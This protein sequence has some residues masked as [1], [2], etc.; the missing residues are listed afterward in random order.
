MF[1]STSVNCSTFYE[2]WWCSY[3]TDEVT[4]MERFYHLP[5][6]SGAQGSLCP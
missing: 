5:R 6:Y 1:L 2:G 4:G 3:F